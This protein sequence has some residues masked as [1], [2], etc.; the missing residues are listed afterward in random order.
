MHRH[1]NRQ[2]SREVTPCHTSLPISSE[3]GATVK[4]F[5]IRRTDGAPLPEWLVGSHVTLGIR[6]G[7]GS[8]LENH[9]SLIGVPGRAA[10]YRIAVQRGT[11]GKGGSR[12][13]HD[14]Y[15]VG[16]AIEMT[17]PFNS[18]PL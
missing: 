10:I 12:C 6:A 13:L 2:C 5:H 8:E 9:Y 7:D 16:D 15:S 18:F 11:H 14:E 1:S 17:G 3:H 4:E